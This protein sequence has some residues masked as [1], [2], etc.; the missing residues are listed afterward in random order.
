MQQFWHA[1]ALKLGKTVKECK[2]DID[3]AEFGSWMAYNR[4]TGFTV[5]K[6]ERILSILCAIVANAASKRGGYK[7]EDFL[8]QARPKVT[9]WQRIGKELEF[10]YGNNK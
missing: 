9:D 2:Q 10:L 4:I 6:T 1:L 5:D 8:M 7:P 3:S